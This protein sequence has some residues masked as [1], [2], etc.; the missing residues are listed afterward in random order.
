MT[1]FDS[2]YEAYNHNGK[3]VP[4]DDNF[5]HI[6][7]HKIVEKLNEG[8]DVSVIMCGEKGNGKS[9]GALKLVEILY[10]KLDVFKGDFN[11]ER[12]FVYEPIQYL[13]VL[14]DIPLPEKDDREDD[15]NPEREAIIIEEAANLLNKSDYHSKMNKTVSDM[16]NIQRKA[17]VLVIYTLPRAGD[18]DSRLKKDVDF[19]VEFVDQGVGKVT[20][21]T[22]DHG[23]LDEDNRRFVDFSREETFVNPNLQIFNSWE[24]HW[25]PDLPS[26]ELLEKFIPL[27]NEYKGEL[28]RERLEELKREQKEEE[29]GDSWL[30]LIEEEED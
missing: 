4:I 10:D 6:F 9:I 3:K 21:Y 14:S 29:E 25:R 5:E 17:N 28:P 16:N 20:G 18:L 12:N 8:K 2:E 1:F 22:F 27:E 24:G 7:I 30:D 23:R 11:V 26:D 19:V 15:I 13:E